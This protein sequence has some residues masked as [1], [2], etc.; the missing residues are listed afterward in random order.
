SYSTAYITPSLFQIY[1]PS[2]GNEDLKP[3][4]NATIEAGVEFTTNTNFRASVVYFTRNEKNYVDFVTV[5]PDL[6][7]S[8]YQNI[9]DEFTADGVEVELSKRFNTQWN[10][11]ANYTFTQADE[12]F[13]LRIPEHKV[14]ASV[15]FQPNVKTTMSLS[16]QYNTDRE[17]R[18]FNPDTFEQETV[19]L[20]AYGLL[21][22]Y[23]SHQV[24]K[25]L[26]LF[27]GLNNV[28]DEN[29]EELFRYSTRGRNVRIGFS[30]E[31]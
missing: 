20:D 31:F 7:I 26:R 17:D 25:N 30:L 10:V 11:M 1:D 5:D 2:Y 18:F 24:M 21:D 6:F 15:Q 3:E 4:E 27:A 13:A 8:Q 28:F 14:N 19:T 29:Y 22:F 16:Y 23:V 9:A 12:R